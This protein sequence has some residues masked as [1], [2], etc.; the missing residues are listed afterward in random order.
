MCA[1]PPTEAEIKEYLLHKENFDKAKV[2]YQKK[3]EAY[4]EAEAACLRQ[5]KVD[6][7]AAYGVTRH[8]KAEKAFCV[9]FCFGHSAGL[10]EVEKF[11][12]DIVTLIK[13]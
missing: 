12:S 6:L 8:P 3:V 9:A 10:Y 7:F 4:N 13:D 2:E 5:F 11:F 1:I